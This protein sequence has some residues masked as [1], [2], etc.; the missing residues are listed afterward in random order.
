MSKLFKDM[1]NDELKKYFNNDRDDENSE[2][3]SFFSFVGENNVTDSW[4]D[5]LKLTRQP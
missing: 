4:Y 3:V 2:L 5:N 1:T